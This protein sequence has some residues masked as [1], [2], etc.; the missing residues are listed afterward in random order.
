MA[1]ALHFWGELVSNTNRENI[2]R[3]KSKNSNK[4]F[5]DKGINEVK[6]LVIFAYNMSP[7]TSPPKASL[8]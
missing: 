5:L 6:N 7:L 8:L 3:D 2:Y 4:T 1:Q